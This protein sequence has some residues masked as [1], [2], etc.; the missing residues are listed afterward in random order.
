MEGDKH[1]N[2]KTIFSMHKK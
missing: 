1:N 2:S